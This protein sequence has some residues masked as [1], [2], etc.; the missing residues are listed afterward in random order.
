MLDKKGYPEAISELKEAVRLDPS[1][2]NAHNDLGLAL[3][4][5]GDLSGAAD[6][7]RQAL[8]LNPKLASAYS[9]LGNI[10][11]ARRDYRGA[12]E[13][14]RAALQIQPNNA[15]IHMNLGSAFDALGSRDQA[16]EQYKLAIKLQP[17]NANAHYNLGL[18][19]AAQLAPEWPK[20]HLMLIQILKNSDP[21]SA[22]TECMIADGMT[23]DAKLHDECLEL[24]KK[25]Q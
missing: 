20:P 8:R 16:I 14:Y 1:N 12:V 25:T 21:K 9:N 3:K 17:G 15:D 2:A 19:Q 6:Q 10:L 22:L 18:K 4:R 7:F 23:H 24:Q 13:Q 5:N 11:Y